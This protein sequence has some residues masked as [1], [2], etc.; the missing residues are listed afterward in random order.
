M[1]GLVWRRLH[2]VLGAS[3]AVLAALWRPL[4]EVLGRSLWHLGSSGG[5]RREFPHTLGGVLEASWASWAVFWDISEAPDAP[6]RPKIIARRTK[7]A[8]HWQGERS[9]RASAAS[10]ASGAI[11]MKL[12]LQNSIDAE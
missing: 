9:E 4:G 11:R 5:T 8:S 3:W 7:M 1:S 2:D 12:N 6:R 10:E